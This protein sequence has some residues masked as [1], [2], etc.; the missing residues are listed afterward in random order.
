MNRWTY[1][2][3]LTG[4]L[5][6]YI[7]FTYTFGMAVLNGGVVGVDVNHYGEMNFEIV[8]QLILLPFV[9][10][11]IYDDFKNAITRAIKKMELK[12]DENLE[13]KLIHLSRQYVACL[14]KEAKH[15]IDNIAYGMI[16][17]KTQDRT[18]RKYYRDMYY[19]FKVM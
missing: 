5:A 11:F 13:R 12:I 8:I 16:Q 3:G 15:T 1:L 7:L 18:L 19:N 9:V 14:T 4:L 2:L 10:I 17:Q 6:G